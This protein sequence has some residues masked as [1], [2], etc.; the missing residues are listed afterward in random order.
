[1]ADQVDQALICKVFQESAKASSCVRW[2]SQCLRCILLATFACFT[3]FPGPILFSSPRRQQTSLSFVREKT[4]QSIR[5]PVPTE[6]HVYAEN[7]TRKEKQL[8]SSL[9]EAGRKGDWTSVVQLWRSYTGCETI[10]FNA[11]MVAAHRCGHEVDASKMYDRLR[12]LSSPVTSPVTLHIGM[13]IFGKLGNKLRV[14][15]IWSEAIEKGLVNKVLAGGRVDAAGELGDI[16]GAAAVLDYMLGNKLETDVVVFNSAINACRKASPPSY[17]AAM[18][19]LDN[20]LQRGL[21]PSIVTFTD[22]VGAH[23]RAPTSKVQN[24]LSQMKQ[25]GIRPDTAFAEMYLCALTEGRLQDIWTFRDAD[26]KLAEVSRER[27]LASKAAMKHFEEEGVRLSG[28]CKFMRKYFEQKL[29]RHAG[30]R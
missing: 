29:G 4:G 27:L 19:I 24:L 8:A 15:E 6:F 21:Q 1:M 12:S 25:H 23:Q 14:A 3:G 11:A 30:K 9:A 22:L 18:F 2:R 20:L 13:K 17:S 7:M 16:E 26:E 5:Q 28:L 10:V